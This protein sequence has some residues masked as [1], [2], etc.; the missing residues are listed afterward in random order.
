MSAMAAVLALGS[1][2]GPASGEARERAAAARSGGWAATSGDAVRAWNTI[3]VNTLVALPGNAGG[4]PPAAQV[5]VGMVQGAV[6]DAVNATEP[7]HYRPYLLDRRFS[8]RASKDAAVA[9]AAYGVLRHLVSTV[10]NVADANRATLLATLATQ[11]QA[12][13]QPIADGP[14]KTKGVDA[15]EAAAAAMIAARTDDGRFGPSQWVPNTAP[16]H[17]WPSLNAAGAQI[18][19]PTPW[20]GTVDPFLMTS[21]SQFRTAGPVSLTSDT[22]TREFNEVKS[23]GAAN[24]TARSPHQT[25]VARWWQSTP[26]LSWNEVARNLADRDDLD[27]VDTAR[28]LAMTNL[29]GADAAINC[30]NDKYHW[31]FWRPWNAIVRAEE[32]GNPATAPQADWTPLISAPYPDHPSGHLC[33]DGAHAGIL[34]KFFGD[35]VPGG[36][37]MTSISTLLAPA[38]A[39]PRVRTFGSFS[40]V[41]DEL[42]EARIWAGLHFRTADVQARLLGSN[43]ADHAAENYFQPVGRGREARRRH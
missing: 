32:D 33:L 36:F 38:P 24:S 4:A 11:Y 2:S 26:V 23:L 28:L 13:L 12:A 20:V 25:Y 43:V 29:S 6:Y 16:G 34:A 1:V 7:K 15:G 41:L 5:H 30:W 40:Q 37:Q 10:P 18:L 35:T 42:V 9:A 31:D 22:W 19:D 27:A 21:S 3:A 8:A 39:D 17:W 14:S